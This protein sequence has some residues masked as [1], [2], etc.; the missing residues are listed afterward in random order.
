MVTNAN[1]IAN[2]AL[3]LLGVERIDDLE[4]PT[5]RAQTMK[6][7]YAPVRDELLGF[8]TW[9]FAMKRAELTK[10]ATA[11]E[12]E[13]SAKFELPSD[14]LRLF[15][16]F[17]H[18]PKSTSGGVKHPWP[19]GPGRPYSIEYKIENNHLLASVDKAFIRYI[20]RNE[21][22]SQYGPKFVSALYHTLAARAAYSLV[23]D[24]TLRSQLF[25]QAEFYLRSAAAENSQEVSPDG[26]EINSFILPR[27]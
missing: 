6:D 8:S 11:P 17:D 12:F 22:V 14:F 7:L 13:F 9:T 25:E 21:D 5:K 10:S 20:Y 15:E 26:F 27:F 16:V 1:Q 18:D 24:K 19:M 3:Q 2:L 23:Q 4:D